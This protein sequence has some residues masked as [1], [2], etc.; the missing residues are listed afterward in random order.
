MDV[1]IIS[2]CPYPFRLYLHKLTQ[3]IIIIFDKNLNIINKKLNEEKQS[4]KRV[5]NY[6]YNLCEEM[7]TNCLKTQEIIQNFLQGNPEKEVTWE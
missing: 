4:E 7:I 5:Y 1:D 2:N 3:T 6:Y